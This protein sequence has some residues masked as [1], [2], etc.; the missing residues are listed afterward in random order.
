MLLAHA[1]K[2]NTS[3]LVQ[4]QN[5]YKS[6]VITTNTFMT[7]VLT[8][9]IPNLNYKPKDFPEYLT[10]FQKANVTALDWS[11]KVMAKLLTVPD[12]I[13]SYND[14]IISLL[15]DAQAQTQT[16][17]TYP[18]NSIALKILT[19]DLDTLSTQLSMVTGFIS[20]A[21]TNIEGVKNDL[22]DMAKELQ[23]IA[24]NAINDE[25]ADKKQ[26]DDLNKAIATLKSDINACTAAIVAAG[27]AT[28]VSVTL[29]T[30]ATIVA[31]PVGAVTWFFVAPVVAASIYVIAIDSIKIKN[32]KNE[33]EALQKEITGVTADVSTLSILAQNFTDMADQATK[34][35]SNL[36]AVLDEWVILENDVNKAITE[37]KDSIV[38]KNEQKFN[39]ILTDLSEATVAWNDAYTQAGA[40]H[41]DL[42]V[43]DSN[44]ELGMSSDE[45]KAAM[46]SGKVV[47]IISYYNS[48]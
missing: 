2:K 18:N 27:I 19:N 24:N 20:G 5:N 1:I 35:Q 23:S 34:V 25:K 38:E 10:A 40:L 6:N 46:A 43:S 8:S 13:V 12:E 39:E 47:D 37:I 28:G 26:I 3:S 17:K 29:G 41:L 32:D 33:I 48:L 36:Q 31:W 15:N 14:I 30:I 44:L 21:I 45:V 16:L 9:Q 22:P 7:S 4:A 42:E 11:N